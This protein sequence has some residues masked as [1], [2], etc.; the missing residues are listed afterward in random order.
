VKHVEIR[1]EILS[2]LTELQT[3]KKVARAPL[4]AL[5]SRLHGELTACDVGGDPETKLQ[6]AQNIGR[7]NPIPTRHRVSSWRYG[8]CQ[9][10]LTNDVQDGDVV[11]RIYGIGWWHDACYRAVNPAF[12]E[13]LVT[14]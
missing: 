7:L 5:L 6:R 4:I 9:R 1:D 8:T 10:C 12:Y 3:G 11:V 13:G 14:A 2:E